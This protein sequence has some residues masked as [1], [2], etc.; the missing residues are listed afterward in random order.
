MASSNSLNESQYARCKKICTVQDR[1]CTYPQCDEF[2]RGVPAKIHTLQGKRVTFTV[3]EDIP[4]PP[5]K[6]ENDGTPPTSES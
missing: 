6:G 2:K 4:T 1:D 3:I 5:T